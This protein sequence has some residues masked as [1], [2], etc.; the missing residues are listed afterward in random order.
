MYTFTQPFRHTQEVTK[1]QFLNVVKL[2]WIQ[3]FPFLWLVAL[4]RLKNPACLAWRRTKG[5]IP[6][7]RAL[8][9]SEMQTALSKIW[10]WSSNISFDNKLC[11]THF[12]VF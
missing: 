3:S 12:Q 1:D 7:S 5:F 11:Y 6:F 9:Q 10:T 2:I 4:L 8:A